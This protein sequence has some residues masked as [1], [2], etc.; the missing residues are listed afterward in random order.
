MNTILKKIYPLL[1]FFCISCDFEPEILNKAET[2]DLDSLEKNQIDKRLN[3]FTYIDSVAF[4]KLYKCLLDSAYSE[5]NLY[6]FNYASDT[7]RFPIKDDTIIYSGV[8][9]RDKNLDKIGDLAILRVRSSHGF[10]HV[11]II[12]IPTH[13]ILFENSIF[14]YNDVGDTIFDCNSDGF[15]DFIIEDMPLSGCCPRTESKAYLY[16]KDSAKFSSE[17]LVFINAVFVPK[18]EMVLGYEYGH[19]KDTYLY[20]VKLKNELLDTVE[21]IYHKEGEQKKYIQLIKRYKGAKFEKHIISKLPSYYNIGGVKEW[22]LM[23]NY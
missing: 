11:L 6:Y 23:D 21:F 15:N 13:N 19:P 2:N 8:I 20:K 3:D 10:N 9:C 1:F 14:W 17:P 12:E 22:F 5:R 16:L 18:E 7:L 4:K